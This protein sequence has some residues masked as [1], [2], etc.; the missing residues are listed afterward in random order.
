M[1][2]RTIFEFGMRY[3]AIFNCG[4][5]TYAKIMWD[6]L[7]L[8]QLHQKT[9]HNI[10]K[11]HITNQNPC[12]APTILEPP[13]LAA[14]VQAG[15]GFFSFMNSWKWKKSFVNSWKRCR[16]WFVKRRNIVREFVKIEIFVDEFVNSDTFVIRDSWTDKI[17][18]VK[19][20]NPPFLRRSWVHE[21]EKY[22]S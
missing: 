7:G 6:I 4:M 14:F 21:N 20:W 19:P 5:Q 18:F 11:S 1:R 12:P 17:T 8:T 16:S 9:P 13:P 10:S 15:I 2:F 22:R 3:L